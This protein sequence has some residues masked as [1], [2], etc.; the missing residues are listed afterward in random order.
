[1]E[2]ERIE[3]ETV[4]EKLAQKL[5]E[6][7][8]FFDPTLELSKFMMPGFNLLKDYGESGITINQEELEV[9]KNKI[10]ETLN[11]YKIGIA[12]IKATIGPTVTLYEIVPEAG[13]R[14]SLEKE[15]KAS[16]SYKVNKQKGG[17]ADPSKYEEMT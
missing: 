13:V 6:N 15:L 11:N 5:V 9:N 8:G 7:Q 14:R 10:V 3:E 4:D 2:I 12:N 17:Q 1:M 16:Q